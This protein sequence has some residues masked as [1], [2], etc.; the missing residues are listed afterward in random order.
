MLQRALGD[1]EGAQR[2]DHHRHVRSTT[3]LL[4]VSAM[5]IDHLQRSGG[6]FVTDLAAN[7]AADKRK[8]HRGE[9]IL[10]SQ[11]GPGNADA[12]E[13]GGRFPMRRQAVE[14]SE[15]VDPKRWAI[16]R[17]H[18]RFVVRLAGREAN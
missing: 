2:H 5:A 11:A 8:V 17:A 13:G 16:E 4:A 9:T 14:S 15:N 3:Q 10:I 1:L 18:L 6:A 7:A 12:G